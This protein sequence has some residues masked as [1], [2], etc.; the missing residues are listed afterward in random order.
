[1]KTS[2]KAVA[3]YTTGN[4]PKQL[5]LFALPFMAS[6]AMQVLYSLV[7]MLI[8]GRFVG[9]FGLSAVSIASQIFTF[10]SMLSMGVSTGGQVY[11]AQLIGAGKK[12]HI[13]PTVGTMFSVLTILGVSISA[14][15]LLFKNGI[16]HLLNAPVESFAM[17]RNYLI[18]CAV[19]LIFSFG[20]NMV[21]AIFRGMGD[22]RHPFLFIMLA[23][24]I[25]LLLDLLFTGLFGWGVTGAALATIIGQAAS[26]LCS[27]LF[28]YKNREDF[29]LTFA[30]S[31]FKIRLKILAPLTRLA[32]PFAISSCAINISMLFVNSMINTLG[33][34]A[35]AVF[36]VGCKLDDIINKISQ[37]IMLALSP[38][39]GQN[40]AAGKTERVKKGVMWSWLYCAVFYVVFTTIYIL[41]NRQMFGLFTDDANVIEQAPVFVSAIIWSFPGMAF[42]RGSAGMVQGIGNAKMSMILGI[43]DGFLFRIFLSYLF[44]I[45]MNMQLYGFVL[46]YGLA[47]YANTIPSTVYFLS[48]KWKKRKSLVENL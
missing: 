9:S 11:I 4:I 22:S 40:I 37:G 12:E 8:V 21:S 10:A 45:V 17:A 31:D 39:V 6:N 18:V 48:G 38:F 36:G 33:V 27:I 28:L 41:Y 1:M 34:Y 19:G 35:S 13:S 44:G 47:C 2:R 7:D 24:V 30:L 23:S 14:L 5:I 25:N 46:G 29:C 15:I 26:F 43:L 16:L 20:Y 42:M 3:D 32:V